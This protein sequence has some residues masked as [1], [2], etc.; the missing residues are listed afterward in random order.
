MG[1]KN[2]NRFLKENCTK[3]SIRK[4]GLNCLKN[5][6]VVIDA[7]IYM[8][9]YLT[10]NALIEHMYLLLSTLLSNDI[11]PFFIFDGKPPEYK[12]ALLKQRRVEKKAA[13]LKYNTV[14]TDYETN[15]DVINTEEE[16]EILNELK[17]LKQQFVRLHSDDIK[18]VKQLLT[19]YGVMYYESPNE[20]DEIC[21]YLVKS[22]K[23]WAC[24][25][26]DMDM[27]IYGCPFVMRN[28]S[29]LNKT[30]LLYDTNEI[31]NELCMTPDH[32]KEIMVL[33][34]T[35]YNIDSHTNL[36][37]TIELYSKYKQNIITDKLDKNVSFYTW[38][39]KNGNYI[40]NQEEL[41]QICE[42]FNMDNVPKA[43]LDSIV[44]KNRPIDTDL[45]HEIMRNEGFV[46]TPT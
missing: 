37:D 42:L 9:R 35:D 10:D 44:I 31:L 33:S 18:R 25:S 36:D 16:R 7:S 19:A 3:K 22:G 1:V 5:K 28:I 46:F 29:L 11:I 32:F 38:L 45:L 20:A 41:M 34:G 6:I 13:E 12:Q 8:Y 30:V 39:I 14:F 26:D 23:A 21:A 4:I 17:Q 2:L 15:Q 27:F 24:M 43:E 40:T